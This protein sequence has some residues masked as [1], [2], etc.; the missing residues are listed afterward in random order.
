MTYERTSESHPLQIAVLAVPGASGE[1][2][3]TFAPGKQDLD[4]M[5]GRWRRDLG[6]DLKAIARWGAS[7]VVTL[8]EQ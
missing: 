4:A 1:L 5:S 8:L 7:L 3:V 6:R 2:G